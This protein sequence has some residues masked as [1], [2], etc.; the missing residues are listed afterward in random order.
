MSNQINPDLMKKN[1]SQRN[2]IKESDESDSLSEPSIVIEQQPVNQ[3]IL[4]ERFN[5]LNQATLS[6]QK[7]TEKASQTLSNVTDSA[8]QKAQEA[9][10]TLNQTLNQSE[11]ISDSVIKSIR[12]VIVNSLQQWMENRPFI[13]WMLN[14]PLSSLLCLLVSISW[15]LNN[16]LWIFIYLLLISIIGWERL[17]VI[18]EIIQNIWLLFLESS[19]V[20]LSF[21]KSSKIWLSF[22]KAYIKLREWLMLNSSKLFTFNK[23]NV[24]KK[25]NSNFEELTKSNQ[26]TVIPEKSTNQVNA[27]VNS[28]FE[29]LTKS[30]Q[31]TVIPEKSTNQVNAQVNSNFEELTKSN[32]ITVIPEKSTNQVNAQV[33][34]P[35]E[36]SGMYFGSQVEIYIAQELDKR[37]VLFFS[38]LQG[39]FS[40]DGSPMTVANNL[41]NGRIELDFLVFHQ[42]KCLILEID[43]IHDQ[44]KG[45]K[46]IDYARDRILLRKGITTVRFT[47]QECLN[48]PADVV[49]EFLLCVSEG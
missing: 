1:I 10:A 24:S 30:N 29:E 47:A 9:K 39:R 11:Q 6:W 3:S 31:I 22:F 19:K 41:L 27:Q 44:N 5:V 15:L 20:W 36:W 21:F 25:V 42:G 46:E 35:Y 37:G 7:T 43:G 38:N 48:Q 14:H 33:K 49:S 13:A 40:Q 18:A 45:H 23:T 34:V 26:I 28:N 32:Q 12:K 8:T 4:S 2:V 16:P 17:A